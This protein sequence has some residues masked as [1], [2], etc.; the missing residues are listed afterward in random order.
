MSAS[1]R[2]RIVVLAGAIALAAGAAT[3]LRVWQHA[4]AHEPTVSIAAAVASVTRVASTFDNPRPAHLRLQTADLVS[5]A[6]AF[7]DPVTM[8]VAFTSNRPMSAWVLSLV[9]DPVAGFSTV[10]VIAVVNAA[11]GAV[12]SESCLSQ[13][14]SHTVFEGPHA[15]RA[16]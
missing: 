14:A 15:F 4:Q 7:R 6:S 3:C 12:V 16:S 2:R 10:R 5:E 8:E 11:T 13:S 9:S 1:V